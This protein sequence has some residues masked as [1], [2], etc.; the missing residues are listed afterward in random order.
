[1]GDNE[2]G[3]RE[4]D[5][6]RPSAARMYH[7]Y[8]SGEAVFDVDKIFGEKI[9]ELFPYADAWAHHNRGFLQRATRFLTDQGIRQ[10]LDIGSGLPTVGNTHEVARA[11][12]PESRVVYVDNDLE[13]VNRAHELLYQQ[14]ALDTTAIIEA[15]LRCPDLILDHPDT[16]RL[17]DFDQPLGLLIVSV[18]PFVPDSDRPHELMA[19]LRDR[20]PA[21]SY[22]AMSHSSLEEASPEIKERIL[23]ITELYKETSDPV[24][25][26]TRDEFAAFFDGFE[27][28]EPGLVH[29]PD[30]RPTEP[31]DSQDPARPCNFAAVGY[32][33]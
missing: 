30:W 14:N 6:S 21:G 4:I 32:K 29:A 28:V 12:A 5:A 24:V 17:I 23:A 11:A 25:P 8:L 26:R 31:V 13:A 3:S 1:M 10:F 33:P 15:D 7:Y 19:H 9:F 18:W 2:F 22:A 27:L 16:R 20:L